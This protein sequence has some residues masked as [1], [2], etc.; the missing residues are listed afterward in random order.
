MEL[1]I[2]CMISV[3]GMITEVSLAPGAWVV[4]LSARDPFGYP[5]EQHTILGCE[6]IPPVLMTPFISS[7]FRVTPL[8]RP[9]LHIIVDIILSG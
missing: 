6:S 9:I 3:L 7:F 2:L 5:N 1:D 8:N 4:L